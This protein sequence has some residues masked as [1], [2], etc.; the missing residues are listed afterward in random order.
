M[1]F[2][3]VKG[4]GPRLCLLLFPLTHHSGNGGLKVPTCCHK[5]AFLALFVSLEF[6]KRTN[7]KQAFSQI[8][9]SYKLV[10]SV[11]SAFIFLSFFFKQKEKKFKSPLSFYCRR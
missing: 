5:G 4:G 9:V 3:E 6:L 11:C 1:E 10:Q 2:G 7:R 8:C